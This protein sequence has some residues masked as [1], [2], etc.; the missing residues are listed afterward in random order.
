MALTAA[1]PLSQTL[2]KKNRSKRDGRERATIEA[3]SSQWLTRR[4]GGLMEFLRTPGGPLSGPQCS[5]ASHRRPVLPARRSRSILMGVSLP[6]SASSPSSIG[7]MRIVWATLIP[8][9][10]SGA[11]SRNPVLVA[12]PMFRLHGPVRKGRACR[13]PLPHAPAHPQGR[14]WRAGARRRPHRGRSSPPP[15]GIIGASVV[16]AHRPRPA[17]HGCAAATC[18]ARGGHGRPAGYALGSLIPRPTCSCFMGDLLSVLH[19]RPLH[20]GAG[21]VFLPCSAF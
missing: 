13:G 6:S 18:V 20:R 11:P 17:H 21:P 3:R 19:R 12:A 7:E 1:G 15:T 14:A 5:L 4:C 2:K 9:R 8:H 10:I 16:D